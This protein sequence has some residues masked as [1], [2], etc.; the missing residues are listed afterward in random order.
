MALARG[1]RVHSCMFQVD[2]R[3]PTPVGHGLKISSK[4][5]GSLVAHP[6]AQGRSLP[7]TSKK[8]T[9]L[10]SSFGNRTATATFDERDR[11]L[12]HFGS[13]RSRTVGTYNK[14]IYRSV[15]MYRV[16]KTSPRYRR[17]YPSTPKNGMSVP[18]S[19]RFFYMN[20]TSL[21]PVSIRCTQ[22][23]RDETA[24]TPRSG[25]PRPVSGCTVAR[26]VDSRRT[27]P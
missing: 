17:Q 23:M 19:S 2:L 24:A 16:P 12:I 15:N 4:P 10:W 11:G 26:D 1:V 7:Y 22:D 8:P 20:S 6:L 14:R 9:L 5:P 3:Y 18:T 13:V 27:A 21:V 25:F